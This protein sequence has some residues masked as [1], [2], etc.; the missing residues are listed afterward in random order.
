MSGRPAH[1][2]R[3]DRAVVRLIELVA[4]VVA[5][6]VD[7]V[8]DHGVRVAPVG[9]GQRVRPHLLHAGGRTGQVGIGLEHRRTRRHEGERANPIGVIE[10]GELRDPSARREADP[11]GVAAPSGIEHGDRV[12]DG[13]RQSVAPRAR[14]PERRLAHAALVV[15]HHAPPAIHDQVA[16]LGPPPVHG[17]LASGDEQHDRMLRRT[18]HLGRDLGAVGPRDSQRSAR[19]IR[20]LMGSSLLRSRMPPQP[21]PSRSTLASSPR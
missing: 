16:E 19:G 1:R 2:G 4:R 8:L 18:D 21:S 3:P 11:V 13:D 12:V 17:R 20:R 9:L 7:V 5:V 15:P 14:R 6:D 10:R